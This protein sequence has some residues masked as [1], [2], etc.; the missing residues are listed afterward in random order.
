MSIAAVTESLIETVRYKVE[1]FTGAEIERI[2]VYVE[3]VRATD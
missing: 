1:E 3:G 2:N